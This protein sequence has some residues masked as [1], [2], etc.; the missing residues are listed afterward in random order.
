MIG[1][2]I[3]WIKY[4][5]ISFKDCLKVI[6]KFLKIGV[7]HLNSYLIKTMSILVNWGSKKDDEIK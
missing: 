2:I 4:S 3:I 6:Q 7:L 5:R 1:V